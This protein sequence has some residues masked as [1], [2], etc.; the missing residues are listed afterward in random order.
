MEIDWFIIK[1]KNEEIQLKIPRTW[2]AIIS[3]LGR[4]RTE[5]AHERSSLLSSG[6]NGMAMSILAGAEAAGIILLSATK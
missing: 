4:A 1:K 5:I 3:S 6:S 2:M